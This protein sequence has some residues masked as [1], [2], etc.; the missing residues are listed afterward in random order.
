MNWFSL[1]S[2]LALQT[3]QLSR[4]VRQTKKTC[5]VKKNILFNFLGKVILLTFSGYK[6][7][8]NKVNKTHFSSQQRKIK[9]TQ[10][11]SR[12]LFAN[13]VFFFVVVVFN[14]CCCFS[15]WKEAWFK[16]SQS[17][18]ILIEF[19]GTIHA[20]IPL[21]HSI[22]PEP[23]KSWLEQVL[24]SRWAKLCTFPCIVSISSTATDL[25]CFRQ[26]LTVLLE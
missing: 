10:N 3:V 25:R 18:Q 19:M 1:L 21:Q 12:L 4:D 9:D 11:C 15:W 14:C 17:Y 7:V 5:Y 2:E 24:M 20:F 13:S 22:F 6:T 16:L 26:S 23:S 8:L